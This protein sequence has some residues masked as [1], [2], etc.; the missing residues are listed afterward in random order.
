MQ[1][2]VRVSRNG[3]IFINSASSVQ[4][5]PTR[6]VPVAAAAAAPAKECAS[7]TKAPAAK[8]MT[9]VSRR[10]ARLKR[11]GTDA[12][13]YLFGAWRSSIV[14]SFDSPLRADFS[15]GC[16]GRIERM[17]YNV[18]P[19]PLQRRVA[20]G[21]TATLFGDGDEWLALLDPDDT[22]AKR[23]TWS[24]PDVG[25]ASGEALWGRFNRRFY[26]DFVFVDDDARIEQGGCCFGVDPCL[27]TQSANNGADS[28]R[29]L[30]F[31]D[32][33]REIVLRVARNASIR[34]LVWTGG[35]RIAAQDVRSAIESCTLPF[36]D[37]GA[38]LVELDAGQRLGQPRIKVS[39]E[40]HFAEPTTMFNDAP[41]VA[42]D[43]AVLNALA[44]L[45]KSA[46]CVAEN[47]RS[48]LRDVMPDVPA[49]LAETTSNGVPSDEQ[50][51]SKRGVFAARFWC[52]GEWRVIAVDGAIGSPADIAALATPP[53]VTGPAP[54]YRFVCDKAYAKL[55]GFAAMPASRDV[56][57]G[58]LL[59]DFT[60]G[61]PFEYD[62]GLRRVGE[63]CGPDGAPALWSLLQTRC[64]EGRSTIAVSWTSRTLASAA[65]TQIAQREGTVSGRHY[66]VLAVAEVR[67]GLTRTTEQLV[68]IFDPCG[69]RTAGRS[70]DDDW[71]AR[72]PRWRSLSRDDL[73]RIG[74]VPRAEDGIFVTSFATF[75][76]V[77]ERMVISRV[78]MATPY[79]SGGAWKTWL[80]KGEW[81]SAR[82][83]IADQFQVA[84]KQD[85]EVVATLTQI[86]MPTTVQLNLVMQVQGGE[87]VVGTFDGPA[88]G[89]DVRALQ[90]PPPPCRTVSISCQ[91]TAADGPFNIVPIVEGPSD[92]A[93]RYVLRIFICG[94]GTVIPT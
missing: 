35:E 21:D 13:S 81:S 24:D 33:A 64:D 27:L 78:L 38:A 6:E 1:H 2:D 41:V 51:L 93:R 22:A 89:R 43:S 77:W 9:D 39:V 42:S 23:S 88:A 14:A 34:D 86:G 61:V 68:R 85:C 49:D 26:L 53:S 65:L 58:E 57:I 60:G 80:V 44:L 29:L 87:R 3:S 17:R 56:G 4:G 25:L 74:G 28:A 5:T 31:A 54:L 8:D 66:G 52:E 59:E 48:L 72:D 37:C 75:V 69:S 12:L 50:T 45:R 67:I 82:R 55:R 73:A 18:A 94:E 83:D 30:Q 19:S 10:A 46:F 71:G 15:V 90:P 70:D 84:V 47:G 20:A 79:T 63:L 36:V 16:D 62:I 40:L 7:P 76:A 92:A 11:V 32:R 91:C